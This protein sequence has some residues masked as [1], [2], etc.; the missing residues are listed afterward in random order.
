MK[1][2]I[3]GKA[4]LEGTSKRTGKDF[5]FN[6]VHYLAPARGVEGLA[7]KTLNLD[8]F[9]YPISGIQVG[10]TYDVEFDDRGYVVAFELVK[11]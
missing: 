5:N 6:Q 2:H 3:E 4:H 9:M 11:G 1:I 8:P 7:A 10:A